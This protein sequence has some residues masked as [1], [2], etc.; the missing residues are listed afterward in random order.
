MA[1]S[2]YAYKYL[3]GHLIFFFSVLILQQ[4]VFIER[5]AKAE[6]QLVENY[7][8]FIYGSFKQI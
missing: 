5:I 4:S 1:Y 3:F 6:V 2:L 7:M 8:V